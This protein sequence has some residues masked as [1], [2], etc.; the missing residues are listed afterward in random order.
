[1]FEI[2]KCITLPFVEVST[3]KIQ[4]HAT[5]P[6]VLYGLPHIKQSLV[7][8]VGT[9]VYDVFVMSPRNRKQVCFQLL[10]HLLCGGNI[11][12]RQIFPKLGKIYK[13]LVIK[14]KETLGITNRGLR[15]T[16]YIGDRLPQIPAKVGIKPSSLLILCIERDNIP[17][18]F[19][20]IA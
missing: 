6:A 7:R 13:Q 9:L 15:E 1:M 2:G 19:P 16:C 11:C 4:K 20:K 17:A 12:T 18:E 8:V 14:F 5:T 10:S 3:H